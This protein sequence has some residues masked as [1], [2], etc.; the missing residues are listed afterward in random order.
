M[1]RLLLW[2][3]QQWMATGTIITM[4]TKDR[5]GERTTEA[6]DTTYL[7]QAFSMFFFFFFFFLLLFLILNVYFQEIYHNG[8]KRPLPSLSTKWMQTTNVHHCRHTND[9][10]K[11]GQS[12]RRDNRGLRHNMSRAPRY[13]SFHFLLIFYLLNICLHLELLHHNCND[14]KWPPRC[15]ISSSSNWEHR[16]ELCVFV[17]L[18]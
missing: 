1:F 16:Y 14:D 15:T 2:E 4:E 9:G 10:Q 13:V 7:D 12:N 11:T 18:Y 3:P 17:L 5:A 8:N 6:Q